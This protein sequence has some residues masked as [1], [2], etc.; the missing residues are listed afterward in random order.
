MKNPTNIR[1]IIRLGIVT[2]V[3]CLLSLQGIIARAENSLEIQGNI[4]LTKNS[5][6]FGKRGPG[7]NKALVSGVYGFNARGFIATN[8]DGHEPQMIVDNERQAGTGIAEFRRDGT[9]TFTLERFFSPGVTSEPQPIKSTFDAEWSVKADC[10]GIVNLME[11]GDVVDWVFV[12]VSNA[13]EMHLVSGTTLAALDAK[14]IS[15]KRDLLPKGWGW[16]KRRGRGRCDA[17]TVAGRYGGNIDSLA[18]QIGGQNNAF[19][20]VY[21]LRADGT[22]ILKMQGF[23]ENA[24]RTVSPLQL[25][26]MQ[27]TWQVKP[28]CTGSMQYEMNDPGPQTVKEVF[29]SVENATEILTVGNGFLDEFDGKRLFLHKKR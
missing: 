17:K 13:D 19:I 20:A 14:R 8:P 10:T 3:L 27:G 12:A 4:F 25:D 9:A 1:S 29:V 5:P 26:E 23:T 6:Y 18:G 21:H 16:S 7:C 11:F 22:L 2:A 24:D 15:K 28:D